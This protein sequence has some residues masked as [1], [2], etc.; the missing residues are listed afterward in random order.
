MLNKTERLKFVHTGWAS[1]QP[2]N[3]ANHFSSYILKKDL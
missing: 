3:A 2:V 1:A